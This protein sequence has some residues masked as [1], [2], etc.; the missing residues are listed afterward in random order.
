MKELS[1]CELEMGSSG[2]GADES[3]DRVGFHTQSPQ[4]F[5]S[6]QFSSLLST[7]SFS[8]VFLLTDM[9]VFVQRFTS[10]LIGIT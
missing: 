10:P 3:D 7:T 5:N 6:I 8:Y 4:P 2:G 9:G 1:A